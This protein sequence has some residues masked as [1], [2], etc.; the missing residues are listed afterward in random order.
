[1]ALKNL[2]DFVTSI[3]NDGFLK[4][5]KYLATIAFSGAGHYMRNRAGADSKAEAD[6]FTIRCDSVQLPGVS[7]ASADGPPRFGYGPQE[8]RPYAVMF[9]EIMLSFIVDNKS[10]VHRM[11]YDWMNCIVNYHGKGGADLSSQSGPSSSSQ[12][13]AYE[14]GYRDRYSAT[15]Q[16]EI[17]APGNLV[18]DKRA[19]PPGNINGTEKSMVFTA[20]NAF[21]MAMPSNTLDWEL[22][23]PVKLNIP[24]AYSD[25]DV[26]YKRLNTKT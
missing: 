22:H 26:K 21:P 19:Y 24:F 25:Y 4:S 20:Y 7:F 10:R 14:V 11:M 1:M 17:Y 16:I 18:E 3:N 2:N 15:L 6:I 5:N 13:S 9:D 8:K 23:E 12:A